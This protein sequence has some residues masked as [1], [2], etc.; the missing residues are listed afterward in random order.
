MSAEP[1]V[2]SMQRC[3][4]AL[5]LLQAN[6]KH[7]NKE[8]SPVD[9]GPLPLKL[10]SAGHPGFRHEPVRQGFCRAVPLECWAP[11]RPKE[12]PR[13]Q[14]KP[15]IATIF[16]SSYPSCLIYVSDK[17]LDGGIWKPL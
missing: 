1:P 2:R 12:R 9:G 8:A 14:L 4:R 11:M 3:L 13:R 6:R 17:E 16:A 7:C 5:R 15:V 10:R